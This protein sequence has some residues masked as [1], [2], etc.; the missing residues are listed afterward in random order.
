M[1]TRSAQQKK[2]GFH[3]S[4]RAYPINRLSDFRD[5]MHSSLKGV[6]VHLDAVAPVVHNASRED[7]IQP[8]RPS[9][10]GVF[11]HLQR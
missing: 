1:R 4:D 11:G 5:G 3:K 2:R 9:S 6:C 10:N 7:A 8:G